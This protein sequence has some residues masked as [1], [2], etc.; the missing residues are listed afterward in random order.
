MSHAA[1]QVT[2]LLTRVL[3]LF[4]LNQTPVPLSLSLDD[5]CVC[6]VTCMLSRLCGLPAAITRHSCSHSLTLS[7]CL[8]HSA[9][10]SLSTPCTHHLMYLSDFA[11]TL[12]PFKCN[13]PCTCSSGCMCHTAN[14]CPLS[15]SC[16]TST[17]ACCAAPNYK[18]HRV[19]HCHRE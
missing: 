12:L 2:L 13:C 5:L 15:C 17:V 11:F 19:F 14:A 7:Q 1:S 10:A 16:L 3:L 6:R 9:I 8:S 18:D 4:L